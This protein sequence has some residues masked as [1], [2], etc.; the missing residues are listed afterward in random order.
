MCQPNGAMRAASAGMALHLDRHAALVVGV[1]AHAADAAGIERRELVVRHVHGER[2]HGARPVRG[3]GIEGRHAVENGGVVDAV[4]RGLGEYDTVDAER[5]VQ[6]LEIGERRIRGIVAAA[7]RE[8]VALLENVDVGVD[9]S[10]GEHDVGHAGMAIRRQAISDLSGHPSS[11]NPLTA[12]RARRRRG[13]VGNDRS[14]RNPA[15]REGRVSSPECRM[16]VSRGRGSVRAKGVA[17]FARSTELRRRARKGPL[18]RVTS[19]TLPGQI[20]GSICSV[21]RASSF[22]SRRDTIRSM[23]K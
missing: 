8:R 22:A 17:L 6:M 19:L 10:L 14:S 18:Q 11:S 7:G 1:E 13:G 2:H 4:D 3:L 5:R 20:P 23:T 21:W 15:G 16:R 12:H 9:R